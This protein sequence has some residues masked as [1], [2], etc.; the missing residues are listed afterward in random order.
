MVVTV[1]FTLLIHSLLLLLLN[2]LLLL[3]LLLTFLSS[4]TNKDLY[5]LRKREKLRL[6]RYVDKISVLSP[7]FFSRLHNKNYNCDYSLRIEANGSSRSRSN[8]SSGTI[9]CF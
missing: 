8:S 7:L 6:M 9:R 5:M 2:L 4:L 3:L 1:A